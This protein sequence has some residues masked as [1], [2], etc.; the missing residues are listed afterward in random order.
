MYNGNDVDE[1][2]NVDDILYMRR[3]PVVLAACVF[4]FRG[5]SFGDNRRQSTLAINS[6]EYADEEMVE[7]RPWIPYLSQNCVS[8]GDADAFRMRRLLSS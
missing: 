7:N 3:A 5:A 1:M 8:K 6:P 4:D 2:Y